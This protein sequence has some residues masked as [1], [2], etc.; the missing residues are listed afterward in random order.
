MRVVVG[1]LG[2]FLGLG[3]YRFNACRCD[4]KRCGDPLDVRVFYPPEDFDIAR[5]NNVSVYS[6]L[7]GRYVITPCRGGLR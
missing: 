7:P 3:P 1:G 6:L 4:L 5:Y 2:S